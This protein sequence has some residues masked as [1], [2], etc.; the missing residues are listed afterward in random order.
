MI[1]AHMPVVPEVLRHF[2]F[3]IYL[4]VSRGYIFEFFKKDAPWKAVQE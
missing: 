1:T 2:L 4:G 3:C